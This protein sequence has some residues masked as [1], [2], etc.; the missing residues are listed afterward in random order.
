VKGKYNKCGKQ[1]HKAVDCRSNGARAN[2]DKGGKGGKRFDG[3][4][5]Y[6]Q[7]TGHRASDCFKKKREQGG[8]QANVAKDKNVGK[9]EE[10]A[11]VVLTTIDEEEAGQASCIMCEPCEVTYSVYTDRKERECLMCQGCKVY[12]QRKRLVWKRALLS[13]SRWMR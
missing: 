7:K 12:K 13:S 11:D 10:V 5:H 2:K 3:K 6:C 8:E 1:G 4:C 9:E